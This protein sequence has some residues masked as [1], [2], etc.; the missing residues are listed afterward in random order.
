MVDSSPR[1]VSQFVALSYLLGFVNQKSNP[2][3]VPTKS[4][5]GGEIE[6]SN[7]AK[8][9]NFLSRALPAFGGALNPG[10]VDRCSYFPKAKAKRKKDHKRRW[11]IQSCS[12]VRKRPYRN[13]IRV[14]GKPTL[15]STLTKLFRALAPSDRIWIFFPLIDPKLSFNRS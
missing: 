12:H 14:H 10:E 5:E 15:P 4:W 8:S 2:H 11:G 6:Q 7:V 1:T 3:R 13:R 9:S